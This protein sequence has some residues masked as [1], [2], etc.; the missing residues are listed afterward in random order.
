MSCDQIQEW[1]SLY[2]DDG[3]NE[4]ERAACDRHLNVCPVCRAQLAELRSISRN[5]RLLTAATEPADLVGSINEA[6]STAAAARQRRDRA[7]VEDRFEDWMIA[8][9]QPRPMR[10]AFSSLASLLLFAAVFMA[11]RPH[12]VA[13]HEAA[14]AVEEARAASENTEEV[15]AAVYDI[16]QPISPESYAAL[17][18]PYN[19]ES[20]SLNPGGALAALT[21]APSR[22]RDHRS[23][24]DDMMVVADV[25]RNGVAS[26]TDVVQAPRDRRMLDDLQKA[27]RQDAAFVPASLDG[28]PDTMHVVFSVQRVNV[29]D[30]NF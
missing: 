7:T 11:L 18:A 8:W 4:G 23:G 29:R 20:P 26:L 30:R 1:L 28:R 27:L 15:L 14:Q 12:M 3:L 21:W 16:N 22:S 24:A 9:F 13:L 19:A 25:F 5:L 6:L 2:F 17:R 10:Y